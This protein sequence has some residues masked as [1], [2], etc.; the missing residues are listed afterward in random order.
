MNKSLIVVIVILLVLIIAGL[1]VGIFI[2][3]PKIFVA[4]GPVACTL[5][6]KLCPDGSYVGRVP[7]SCEFAPCP[8]QTLYE[9]EPQTENNEWKT[10][11]DGVIEFSYPEK[12]TAEYIDTHE[13][14]PKVMMATGVFS[15][16]ETP[17]E[18]SLSEFVVRRVVDDRVYCVRVVNEAAAGSVYSTY[19]YSTAREGDIISLNFVL[20]YPQCFNYADERQIHECQ[21]ERE[22]FDLDGVIDRIAET[23][24]IIN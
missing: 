6:A 20:R 13:W 19:T 4:P 24:K 8:P 9:V 23:V 17:A 11:S 12:L 16:A 3:L 2:L 5:E 21:S 14:P 10:S 1:T 15:C 7:P 22:A 18:S